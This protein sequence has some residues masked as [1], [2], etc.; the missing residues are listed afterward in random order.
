MS[1]GRNLRR[2]VPLVT[3]LLLL[4]VNGPLGG[5]EKE[6]G[7][8]G[9]RI[10]L[11]A[12]AEKALRASADDLAAHLEKMTGQKFTIGSE[13]GTAGIFLVR[14]DEED[15]CSAAFAADREL[16]SGHLLEVSR[17]IVGTGA[18]SLFRIRRQHNTPAVKT[19]LFFLPT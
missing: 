6:D 5:Q 9:R 11:P 16:L 15:S 19:I 1:I 18:E 14:A 8:Y 4:L 10:V 2:C 13:G 7:L 3:S 17:E 12:N